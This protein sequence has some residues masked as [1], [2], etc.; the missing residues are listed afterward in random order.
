[1]TAGPAARAGFFKSN[2]RAY[3][4]R[5]NTRLSKKNILEIA[6]ILLASVCFGL[7]RNYF[8]SEKPLLLFTVQVKPVTPAARTYFGDADADLVRQMAPTPGTVLLDARLP[9]LYARGHIPGA[10]NLPVA[11][12]AAA[13]PPLLPRLRSAGMVIVYCGGP[14]CPDAADLAGKLFGAG[15]GD[16]LVYREGLK[17]WQQRGYAVAR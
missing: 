13:L 7:G 6:V 17:D 11:R 9:E 3:S 14:A 4:D 1:M 8:F 15:I 2:G 5:M 10:V 12:F 16:I